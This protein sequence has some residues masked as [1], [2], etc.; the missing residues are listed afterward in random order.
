MSHVKNVTLWGGGQGID[1][2][3]EYNHWKHAASYPHCKR[4]LKNKRK[5]VVLFGGKKPTWKDRFRL[6]KMF[7]Q[8]ANLTSHV[9][10]NTQHT[11]T[12]ARDYSRLL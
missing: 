3:V 2:C 5:S 6:A 10:A 8:S 11:V 4:H 9:L 1:I 7:V 12:K